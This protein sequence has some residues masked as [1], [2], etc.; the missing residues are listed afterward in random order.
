MYYNYYPPRMKFYPSICLLSHFA[1]AGTTYI[2]EFLVH[3]KIR[4]VI[5]KKNY[6]YET[7]EK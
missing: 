2:L 4:G 1:F 7:D 5:I 6:E 3:S